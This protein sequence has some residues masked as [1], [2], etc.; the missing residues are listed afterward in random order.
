VFLVAFKG[1]LFKIEDDLQVAEN[2]Y[3]Y[4][5]CGCGANYAISAVHTLVK[6]IKLGK[7]EEFVEIGLKCAVEFSVGVRSPFKILKLNY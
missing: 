7:D 1:R 5:S 6:H 2:N 4:D 3:P